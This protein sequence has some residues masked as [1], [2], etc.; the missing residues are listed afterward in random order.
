VEY[1]IFA[2]VIVTVLG[3]VIITILQNVGIH[4][5]VKNGQSDIVKQLEEK[6][7]TLEK[8]LKGGE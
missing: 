2:P 6:V 1:Y 4:R 7:K 3:A 8:R 5:S